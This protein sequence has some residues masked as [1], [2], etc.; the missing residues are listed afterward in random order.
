[1][2]GQWIG[3]YGESSEG[4]IV[5][6]IDERRTYYQGVAYLNESDRSFPSTAAFFRTYD[7]SSAAKFRTDVIHPINPKT[8]IPDTWDEVR[9]HYGANVAVSEYADVCA[10]YHSDELTL[11]WT[12]NLGAVGN[13]KLF[14]SRAANPS[15]LVPLIQ[16]WGEFK[17]YVERLESRRFLFRGQTEPWR[18]RTSFHRAGR[19]DLTRFLSEDIQILHK[20]LSA[21]TRHVFN[22]ENP[23]ENGAFF[24]L[25]QHH[26]YPTPLLDWTYSPYVAAFFA[27]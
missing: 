1:M 3:R 20:H 14:R 8:G 21:R 7:K 2:N 13:C 16:E 18:L 19:A 6:N 9:K 24:N 15:E 4:L 10:N 5:V 26:G 11:A 22:L 27:Y 23:N 12:T 17:T 25:V